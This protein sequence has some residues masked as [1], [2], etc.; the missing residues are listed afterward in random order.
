MSAEK[1]ATAAA[2]N[3]TSHSVSGEC[4]AGAANSCEHTE[5]RRE[6]STQAGGSADWRWQADGRCREHSSK[7]SQR[8]S[9]SRQLRDAQ[10]RLQKACQT[11]VNT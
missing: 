11:R 7:D 6:A 2:T 8:Q 10:D 4:T 1:P 3:A 5:E 9:S